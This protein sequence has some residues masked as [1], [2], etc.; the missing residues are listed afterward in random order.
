MKHRIKLLRGDCLDLLPKEPTYTACVTDPPYGLKFMGWGWD[1]GVPG[2]PF[3]EA[4]RDACFPGAMLLAFGGTRTHHHLMCAI[5]DAGW[6]I[7][8]CLM[9]VYGSGFPK[10]HNI[11]K[12]IDKAAGA[13]REVV[14]SK[15]GQPGY[16]KTM[17]QGAVC[18]GGGFGGNGDGVEE[19]KITA[20]ATEAAKLWD[21]WGTALK[22]AHEIIVC[23]RKPLTAETER[24]IIVENLLTLEAKLWS[25]LPA[26][27]AKRSFGLSQAEQDAAAASAQWSAD[28]RSSLR[29]ALSAQTDTLQFVSAII[30]SL[31]TVSSWRSI[32]DASCELAKMSTTS[33]KT[34]QTID[35]KTLNS[36]LSV[37]TP[38]SIIKAELQAPGSR[39]NAEP[40]ARYLNA[41][42]LNISSTRELSVLGS[43]ISKGHTLPPDDLGLAPNWEPIILAMK[44]LDGTFAANALEHGVAGINVDGCRVGTEKR[45]NSSA[46]SNEIYGQ[47]QGE[48]TGGR[49]TQGRWPANLILSYPEDEY[50]DAGNLLPNPGKDEVVGLFPESKK[51]SA[52]GYNFEESNND[53]PCHIAKNIKSG[54][55]FG[56]SGSAARFFYCAKASKPER[57]AGGQVENKH[58]TVKPLALMEYLV[59]L[60]TMPERNHIVDP[61]CGSGSTLV[62]CKKLGI[63]A[64][65]MDQDT[66]TIV[67]AMQRLKATT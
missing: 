19:C 37:L 49:E 48:E 40:A 35:W 61:F 51:G 60:V 3:W 31:S 55:H 6:E 27:V 42:C 38:H 25:L 36:C 66:D 18:Y 44:P 47:V 4:I 11:S 32:L 46:S 52:S 30:S 65:G 64:T 1:H 63:R 59:K 2:V 41:V 28:E 39:L 13:E 14:G 15:A 34:E 62:A 12:A 17:G 24:G 45:F 33:T 16:S 7:R 21:G 23:A 9:W 5:E 43:A 53:N 67:T 56:D 54:V 58:P 8:D 22:P 10:S 26:S 29:D 20:P 57:T 50:D